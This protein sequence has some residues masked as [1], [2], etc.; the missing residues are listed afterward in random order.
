MTGRASRKLGLPSRALA[1]HARTVELLDDLGLAETFVQRGLR[2]TGVSMW[3]SSGERLVQV[4]F[5]E[6]GGPLP[7]VLDLPQSETEALLERRL[8][9]LGVAVERRTE[10]VAFEQ[11]SGCVRATLRAPTGEEAVEV[12]WVIGCDGAHSAIRHGLAIGFEGATVEL[13]W[14]L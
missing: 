9:E 10:L 12:P 6:I 3:S 1:I 2:A 5:D 4:A 7:F 8:G 13:D 11:V 14:G